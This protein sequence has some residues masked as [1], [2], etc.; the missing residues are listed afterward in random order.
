MTASGPTK[1]SMYCRHCGYV[2][3]G[4]GNA[5]CPECGCGFDADNPRS[6]RKTPRGHQWRRWRR[7][8][9]RAMLIVLAIS[10]VAGLTI[11]ITMLRPTVL[12]VNIGLVETNLRPWEVVDAIQA[13]GEDQGWVPTRVEH[14]SERT[15]FYLYSRASDN[16]QITFQVLEERSQAGRVRIFILTRTREPNVLTADAEIPQEL[17]KTLRNRYGAWRI[18]R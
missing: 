10:F 14:H 3:D 13:M 1:P 9:I 5:R 15:S 4:L 17:A 2:L 8:T 18:R 7:T 6:Y 16:A 12:K 11:V